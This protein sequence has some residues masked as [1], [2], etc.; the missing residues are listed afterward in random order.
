MSPMDRCVDFA[1]FW[2]EGFLA[3]CDLLVSWIKRIKNLKFVMANMLD[4]KRLA[5]IREMLLMITQMPFG[6]VDTHPPLSMKGDG[7]CKI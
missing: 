7:S 1:I 4:H 3:I 2:S 6:C 5:R